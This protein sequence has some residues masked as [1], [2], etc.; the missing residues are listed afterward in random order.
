MERTVVSEIVCQKIRLVD[1]QGD[2]VAVLGTEETE[3]TESPN[4]T[5]QMY[6]AEGLAALELSVDSQGAGSVVVFNKH[7]KPA[8]TARV[9]S[10]DDSGRIVVYNKYSQ[11]A[12]LV[13]ADHINEDSGSITV[14]REGEIMAQ[15]DSNADGG[16]V[17]VYSAK[18]AKSGVTVEVDSDDDSGDIIVWREGEIMA[19]VS[20]DADGGR[21]SV[22]STKGGGTVS[23]YVD[24]DGG[25]VAVR[26]GEHPVVLAGTDADGSGTVLTLEDGNITSRMPRGGT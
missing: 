9:D 4:P 1:S 2:T 15:V 25:C 20:S 3:E 6:N 24:N 26:K 7:E 8:V 23:V 19:R 18:N 10:D 5:F 12:V 17:S 22:H 21:V 14:W 13:D 16:R 11:I